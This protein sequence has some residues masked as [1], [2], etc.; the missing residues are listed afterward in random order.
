MSATVWIW[1]HLQAGLLL[2][3]A[4][5]R[6]PIRHHRGGNFAAV[7]LGFLA[8]LLPLGRVDL[9]GYLYGHSGAIS[10]TG[11]ALLATIVL[12]RLGGPSLLPDA[13]RIVWHR[14][15]L[16]LALLLY[17]MA[18]GL[19]PFD[20][21][22]LGFGGL[23]LPLVLATAA[24]L[25]WFTDS[26]AIALLLLAVIWGWLLKLGESDNLWDYLLDIWTV[27]VVLAIELRRYWS[28]PQTSQ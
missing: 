24:I 25:A 9:A 27:L 16:L 11:L 8:S 13:R 7:A 10:I 14:G 6:L 3:F 15:V 5:S 20:P 21:Y 2:T 12:E 19:G 23:L 4:V 17:P 28:K 26:R 1:A 22:G 18:L